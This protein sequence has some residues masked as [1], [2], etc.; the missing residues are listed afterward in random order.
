MQKKRLEKISEKP[1][2]FCDLTPHY[3]TENLTIEDI[4]KVLYDISYGEGE[5]EKYKEAVQAS[6]LRRSLRRSKKHIR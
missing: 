2:A 6:K 3:Y 5:K 1:R 4:E